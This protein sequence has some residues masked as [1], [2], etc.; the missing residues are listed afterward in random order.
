MYTFHKNIYMHNKINKG[1]NCLICFYFI[2]FYHVKQHYKI[3]KAVKNDI[4]T[5]KKLRKPSTRQET[6]R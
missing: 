5:K 3:V 2:L 4:K 6:T 1:I